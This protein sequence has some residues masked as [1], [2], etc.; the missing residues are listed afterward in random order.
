MSGW[1]GAQVACCCGNRSCRLCCRFLPL[2][3][4]STSTRLMYTLFLFFGVGVMCLM[5]MPSIQH[6][7]IEKIS[8][9][10]STCILL[11]VRENCELLVGY[12]AVYRVAFAFVIFFFIFATFTVGVST[13]R[14]C[15]AGLHNGFWLIKFIMLTALCAGAFSIPTSHMDTFTQVWMYIALMGAA[16]FIVLQMMM[17]VDFA[18]SW[19]DNWRSK[20]EDNANSCWFV[21]MVLCAMII[22]TIFAAGAILLYIHFT[23]PDGCTTNKVFIS[24]NVVLC[25]A[26]S[27]ISVMP[28][29]EKYTGDARAGLLQASFI[30]VYVLY[31]TWSA[32]AS[33]PQTAGLEGNATTPKPVTFTNWTR[34]EEQAAYCKPKKHPLATSEWIIPYIGIIVMFCTVIYSSISTTRRSYRLGIDLPTSKSNPCEWCFPV[35][36]NLQ[37]VEQG[38][39]Q[40]VIRNEAEG[41]V[42][43]YAFFHVVYSLAAMYLM[44]QLTNWFRPQNASL[45]PFDKNEA[46]MW[47]K[48][49]SS[50]VCILTYLWTILA[51][52]CCPGN[53]DRSKLETKLRKYEPE[54]IEMEVPSALRIHSHYNGVLPHSHPS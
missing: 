16:I 15:R 34:S 5:L 46:A 45:S 49:I 48:M 39:G 2:I 9:Y 38:R 47:V 7:M 3:N 6:A 30:S 40:G 35:A 14:S 33:Q 11:H 13:S 17:L 10:N 27:L 23:G 12:M 29:V 22:Y 44:M 1:C 42:Y 26:S 24:V 51:P 41:V 43:S 25:L 53:L 19:T 18:H 37:R 21:A 32:L 28:Y 4:E 52:Q 31:L 54:A 8:D 36:P 20:V 50:W